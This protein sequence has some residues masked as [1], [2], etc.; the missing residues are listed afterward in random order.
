M[1]SVWINTETKEILPADQLV[2]DNALAEMH[3]QGINMACLQITKPDILKDQ[4][5]KFY[6]VCL[7]YICRQNSYPEN[8]PSIDKDA[9]H[10]HMKQVLIPRK[11]HSMRLKSGPVVVKSIPSTTKLSGRQFKL[12]LQ[13][14]LDWAV[15]Q[16]YI[17]PDSTDFNKR[18]EEVGFAE[19]KSECLDQLNK[20]LKAKHE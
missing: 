13:N 4:M 16:G 19:A 15:G 2:F 12:Y 18:C 8:P 1:K 5:H 20:T 9:L 11:V 17:V 10:A 7:E 3:S 6:F 14:V